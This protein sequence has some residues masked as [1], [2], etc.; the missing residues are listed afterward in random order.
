[1]KC[2]QKKMNHGQRYIPL[3]Y[4]EMV[5]CGIQFP[6]W[7]RLTSANHIQKIYN[8]IK[9]YMETYKIQPMLPGCLTLCHCHPDIWIMV[10]GQ[11][12]FLALKR[13]YDEQ[14]IDITVMCC[15]LEVEKE[16]DA[17]HWFS[18][19]NS[20]LPLTRIPA[21]Q[22]LTI[23]NQAV[24]LLYRQ[25]P[26]IFSDSEHPRRPH[27][28]KQ[29]LASRIAI[30]MATIP[31][32]STQTPDFI[33][34]KLNEHNQWLTTQPLTIF[35]YPGESAELIEKYMIQAR[36]KGGYLFG[37]Y[38]QYE[39]VKNCFNNSKSTEYKKQRISKQ[40]RNKVWTTFVGTKYDGNCY[41]CQSP[42]D[43]NSFHAGHIIPESKGGQNVLSNLRPV[44][45]SC[46][47]S[48]GV[49]NLDEFKM[50]FSVNK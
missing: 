24:E 26:L 5:K 41:S 20:N 3:K 45:A 15:I 10:D 22:R 14:K 7:Q 47:L 50:Q 36:K 28:N 2:K 38:K 18:I 29:E 31:E 33:V 40:L 12:R 49:H 44:C 42:I 46:N 35:Q 32:L 37:M 23:P 48:C 8:E 1:M 16:S 13:L 25:C 6:D 19:V 27:I 9:L 39:F 17:H 30:V 11:H 34:S 43:I 21:S 4:S